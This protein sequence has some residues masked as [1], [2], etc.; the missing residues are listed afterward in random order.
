MIDQARNASAPL[1]AVGR[2]R[3]EQETGR[4]RSRGG[5]QHEKTSNT[6]DAKGRLFPSADRWTRRTDFAPTPHACPSDQRARSSSADAAY[7]SGGNAPVAAR[8]GTKTAFKYKV[9]RKQT[10]ASTKRHTKRHTSE[11]DV[12]VSGLPAHRQPA[13]TGFARNFQRLGSAC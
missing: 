11:N 3:G 5:R 8:R 10:S 1:R 12:C 7:A 2:K 9:E 4:L 13:T 6:A